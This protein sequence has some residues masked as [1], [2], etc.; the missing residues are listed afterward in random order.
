M[1]ALVFVFLHKKVLFMKGRDVRGPQAFLNVGETS[2]GTFCTKR[3]FELSNNHHPLN[4]E[5]VGGGGVGPVTP[6]P[7]PPLHLSPGGGGG[8]EAVMLWLRFSHRSFITESN[9]LGVGGWGEEGTQ[10]EH[11]QRQDTL[12]QLKGKSHK[13]DIFVFYIT[14][15]KR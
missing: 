7:T 1:K 11:R 12:T 15:C 2:F 4:G 13:M 5:G 3:S 6:P 9:G 14:L 10:F 8:C